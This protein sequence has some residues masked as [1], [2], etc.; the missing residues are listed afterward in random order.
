MKSLLLESQQKIDFAAYFLEVRFFNPTEWFVTSFLKH[1]LASSQPLVPW[2]SFVVIWIL[3]MEGVPHAI[4]E[5]IPHQHETTWDTGWRH[6][7]EFEPKM[8]HVVI[9][10]ALNIAFRI[11]MALFHCWVL[12]MPKR[13]T[14]PRPPMHQTR[15]NKECDMK[16]FQNIKVIKWMVFSLQV[17]RALYCTT[18]GVSMCLAS[19]CINHLW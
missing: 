6:K 12:P 7:L 9:V 4:D 15:D 3:L 2:A 5:T 19:F 10:I 1:Y 14:N 16:V 18:F 8:V 11:K 17:Q 13:P